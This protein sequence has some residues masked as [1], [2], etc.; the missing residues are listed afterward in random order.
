MERLTFVFFVYGLAFFAMGLAIA[1]ESRRSTDPLL[2]RPLHFLA[3]FGLLHA[4]VEWID[5]W[6]IGPGGA[7]SVAPA[8]RILRLVLFATSI[9]ALAQ[10]GADVIASIRPRIAAVRGLPPRPS[11]FR[12]W[13]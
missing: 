10:F 8:L 4:C 5:M 7:A 3:A 1:L 9:L 11:A 12:A 13:G 6:L 2:N